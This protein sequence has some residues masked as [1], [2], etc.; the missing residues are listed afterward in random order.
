M[1]KSSGKGREKG[2]FRLQWVIQVDRNRCFAGI[3][4]FGEEYINRVSAQ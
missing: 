3:I 1:G 2:L 4:H